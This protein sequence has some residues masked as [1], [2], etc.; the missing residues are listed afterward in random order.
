MGTLTVTAK[1]QI[2]LPRR[3]LQRLGVTPGQ[4][5]EVEPLPD[6]GLALRPRVRRT[7]D[8]YVGCLPPPARAL[9]LDELDEWTREGWTSRCR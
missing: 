1:G 9:S 5:V 7:L 6:G 4:Q 2:T 8:D 3:W